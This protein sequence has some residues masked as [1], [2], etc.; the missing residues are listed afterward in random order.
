MILK[1]TIVKYLRIT[2]T[3]DLLKCFTKTAKNLNR[4]NFQIKSEPFIN[5]FSPIK[6]KGRYIVAQV[7]FKEFAY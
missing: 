4:R 6:Q 1:N 3:S 7:L 2:V 5:L